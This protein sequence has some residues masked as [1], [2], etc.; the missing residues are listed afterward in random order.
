VGGLLLV[1]IGT[2]G[3]LAPGS[4]F[5]LGLPAVVVGSACVVGGLLAGSRQRL[6]TRYRPD[7]WG[8]AEWVVAGSGLMTLTLYVVAGD[9]GTTGLV[10][11]VSPLAVPPLP[12]LPVAASLLGLLPLAVT[13]PPSL[14]R[15]EPP[16][17]AAEDRGAEPALHGARPW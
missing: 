7:R 14:A 6:R 17:A 15:P 12:L 11:G 16:P 1:A 8:F 2:Y 13:L 3:V 5:G 9:I 4:L 10:V